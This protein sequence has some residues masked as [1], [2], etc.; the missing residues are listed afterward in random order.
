M[1]PIALESPCL[2]DLPPLMVGGLCERYTM[3]NTSAIPSQ[4]ERFS[5]YVG[6]IPGGIDGPAYGVCFDFE[7]NQFDYLCGIEVSAVEGLAREFRHVTIPS[8]RYAIFVIEHNIAAIQRVIYTIW[9]QWLPSSGY[10]GANAP[11]VECYR[12]NFDPQTGASGF[13][14]WVAIES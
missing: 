12:E 13:E 3:G 6:N 5:R 2:A 1:E 14:I 11:T 9:N 4:W 10:K 8:H 7:N